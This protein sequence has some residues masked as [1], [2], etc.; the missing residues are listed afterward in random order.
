MRIKLK[1]VAKMRIKIKLVGKPRVKSKLIFM[2]LKNKPMFKGELTASKSFLFDGIS[3][4]PSKNCLS[5]LWVIQI[6]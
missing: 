4:K 3:G 5:R 6:F 1:L 2:G